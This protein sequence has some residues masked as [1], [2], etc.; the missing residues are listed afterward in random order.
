MVKTKIRLLRSF[1]PE[2]LVGAIKQAGVRGQGLAAAPHYPPSSP[3]QGQSPPPAPD[4]PLPTSRFYVIPEQWK[5]RSGVRAGGVWTQPVLLSVSHWA[6]SFISLG[7]GFPIQFLKQEC[8][9]LEGKEILPLLYEE[10]LSESKL[11]VISK[12]KLQNSFQM[13]FFT[14]NCL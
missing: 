3:S 10:E 14:E 2:L 6:R 4:S 9:T 5:S 12:A 11:M 8:L 1:G 13:I 7:L